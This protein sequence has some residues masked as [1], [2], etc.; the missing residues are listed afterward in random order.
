M[1]TIKIDSATRTEGFPMD[2]RFTVFAM[3]D[4]RRIWEGKVTGSHS[5][6]LDEGKYKWLANSV[7]E[8]QP[9]AVVIERGT[10]LVGVDDKTWAKVQLKAPRMAR[11]RMTSDGAVWWCG[12]PDCNRRFT[13]QPAVVLHEHDHYGVDLRT[14]PDDPRAAEA[15]EKLKR[16]AAAKNSPRKSFGP[17][18]VG[19]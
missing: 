7:D 6:H 5:M 2:T 4:N 14:K 13:S 18:G 10:L 3:P 17:G 15:E 12:Y 19:R 8:Y 1:P 9:N 16:D 11:A